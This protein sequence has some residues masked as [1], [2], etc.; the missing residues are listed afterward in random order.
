[1]TIVSE[2]TKIKA[3]R[4]LLIARSSYFACILTRFSE[5]LS[6]VLYLSIPPVFIN[7]ILNY[8][9]TGEFPQTDQAGDFWA[10]LL[11]HSD[12]LILPALAKFCEMKLRAKI[13]DANVVELYLLADQHY[14][15]FLKSLCADYISF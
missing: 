4:D 12:Y 1:V 13:T 7:H 5:S 14:F 11:I 2:G 3:S 9:Y 10:R 6:R 15:G 8:I